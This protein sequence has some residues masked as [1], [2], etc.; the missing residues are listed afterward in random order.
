[1]G[2]RGRGYKRVMIRTLGA[3]AA[4]IAVLGSQLPAAAQPVPGT[5]LRGIISSSISTKNAYPG[6]DVLARHVYSSDGSVR[7]AEMVGTV[8][9]VQRAGQGR[10]A[11]ISLRFRYLN[12]NGRTYPIDGVVTAMSANTKSNA[13]KEVGGT[14]GGMLV[15][16]AIFR[17]LFAVAGGGILGAIGGFLIAKNNRQNMEIPAG[18]AIDVH[19]ISARRQAT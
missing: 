15:G 2:D 12:V 7:D 16:S 9:S 6:E 10:P 17:T 14:V 18:S 11:Q 1:M 5:E 8:T 3:L 4:A 19:V 13:L